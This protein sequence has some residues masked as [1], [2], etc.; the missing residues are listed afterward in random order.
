[1][2]IRRPAWLSLPEPH[3][4]ASMSEKLPLFP[5]GTVLFP[6]V[7][8][9]LHIF[10][11]R[12]RQLVGDLLDGPEPREFGVIAIRKGRETGI[13]GVSSLYEIGCT[14]RLQ[15]VTELPDGRYELVTVGARRF[16]L[17]ALDESAVYLQ[18]TAD[19]LD[20]ADDDEADE[21]EAAAAVSAVQRAFAGYV[22][23]LAAR[24]AARISLPELPDDPLALSYLVAVAMIADV[25]A[26]Q[27]LLAEPG[28]LARLNAERS[29]L[30]RET[31]M[32]KSLTSAPAADLRYTP[33]S[34][35]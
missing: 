33:Y 35:N 7:L 10:E 18:G 17:G 27:A 31:T 22:E 3:T 15:Q 26:K 34:S 13:D 4:V 32:L 8:L 5:L 21:N 6:G 16:R 12:Y 20:E 9:P 24:G 30:A 23:A 25:P 28:P 29:V 19:Y 14:A 11:D 1:M 2:A